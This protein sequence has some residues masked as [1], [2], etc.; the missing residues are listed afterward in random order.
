MSLLL[1]VFDLAQSRSGFFWLSTCGYGC[2]RNE[3]VDRQPLDSALSCDFDT[4]KEVG[5]IEDACRC[6]A[7]GVEAGTGEKEWVDIND[8]DTLKMVHGPQDGWHLLGAMK[9][10]A[11][12]S[13]VTL[14]ANAWDAQ[15]G[16]RLTTEIS[17]RVQL[18]DTDDACVG[19]Y[20]DI[21]LFLDPS[22][23]PEST[24]PAEVACRDVRVEMCAVDSVGRGGCDT[25]TVW[26]TP[27]PADVKSGMVADCTD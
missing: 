23:F 13:V 18:Y 25:A 8:G 22:P 12:L 17:T 21:Y 27:D 7:D 15:T 4:G 20:P 9:V 3:P 14:Q 2:T 5:D 6:E 24:I 26:V 19:M 10:H 11:T 1:G 16:Q